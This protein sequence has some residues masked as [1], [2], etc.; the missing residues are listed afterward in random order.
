M[1]NVY[2]V[3]PDNVLDMMPIKTQKLLVV[4]PPPPFPPVPKSVELMSGQCRKSSKH[5]FEF[6]LSNIYGFS[7]LIN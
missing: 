4:S 1:K 6:N 3:F 5:K 7:F 2:I